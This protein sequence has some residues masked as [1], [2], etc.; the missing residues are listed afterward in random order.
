MQWN[1]NIQR[2]LAPNLTAMIALVRS[3]GVHMIFRADDIN[4]SLP[5]NGATPPYLW[6]VPLAGQPPTTISP[7]IGRMDTLQ[8][9]NDSYFHGLEVQIEKRMSHGFQVQAGYTWSR[10]IDG[11]DGS[12]ASDSFQNSIPFVLLPSQISKGSRRLQYHA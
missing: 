3:R 6:P 11:G 7:S 10:A 1:L 2:E 4:M 12:I 8:W 9:T 5:I